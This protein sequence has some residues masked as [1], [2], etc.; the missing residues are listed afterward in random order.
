MEEF[1][2]CT[3]SEARRMLGISTST[4][5]HLVDNR[6]IRK[7]TPPGRKQ[8]YYVRE[9]VDKILEERAAITA[10]VREFNRRS[11]PNRKIEMIAEPDWAHPSLLPGMIKLDYTVYGENIVGDLSR[12]VERL[13]RNPRSTMVVFDRSDRDTILGY[14]NVLPLQEETILSILK[15]GRSELSIDPNEIETYERE[16]T[17]VLYISNIVIHPDYPECLLHMIRAFFQY[18]VVEYPKRSIEK[19]YAQAT[20]EAGDVLIRKL[21]FSPLYNISD[22]AY[23]LDLRKKGVSRIVRTFQDYLAQKQARLEQ[24]Q[25]Q[26]GQEGK[27]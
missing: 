14:I 20:T 13:K 2:L 4:F 5:K 7:V 27:G 15:E 10:S 25:A 19:I 24:K 11:R 26:E 17:Y 8:G 22:T 21:F 16:G 6:V 23:V 1:E 9:D 3:S 18:W 12:S